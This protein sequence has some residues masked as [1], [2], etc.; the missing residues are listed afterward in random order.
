[1]FTCGRSDCRSAR[2]CGESYRRRYGL[3]PQHCNAASAKSKDP[4]LRYLSTSQSYVS[5]QYSFLFMTIMGVRVPVS[6]RMR[7]DNAPVRMPV[8]VR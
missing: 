1:M 2:H 7:V 5:E 6:M 3:R 8:S 4:A